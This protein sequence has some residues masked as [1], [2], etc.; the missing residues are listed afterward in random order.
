VPEQPDTASQ[1]DIEALLREQGRVPEEHV[2]A[3]GFELNV[4]VGYQAWLGK[5][6]WE[7]NGAPA[8]RLSLGLRMPWFLSFGVTLLDMSTDFGRPDTNAVVTLAPGFY[9]RGHSQRERKR[10][11]LDIWGGVGVS[12]IAFSIAAFDSGATTAQR[13]AGTT[14]RAEVRDAVVKQLGVSQVATSQSVNVPIELGATFYITRGVGVSLD[15]AFTFWIPTQLCYHDSSDR[16]CVS[17]GLKTQ[18]SLFMGAGVSFL[19]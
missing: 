14:T 9:L 17:D 10:M 13:L 5:G 11:S 6:P 3:T 8:L 19:P 18:H 4:A 15:L 16:Y 7:S 2:P 1:A 12:P